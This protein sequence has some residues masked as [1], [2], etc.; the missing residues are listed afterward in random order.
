MQRSD[1]TTPAFIY[2]Q[3]LAE[4]KSDAEAFR[5]AYNTGNMATRDA[6]ILEVAK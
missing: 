4:G 3:A 6:E 5:L 1:G 2:S